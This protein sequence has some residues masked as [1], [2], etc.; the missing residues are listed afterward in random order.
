MDTFHNV[1][2]DEDNILD[3]IYISKYV[4]IFIMMIFDLNN[5]IRKCILTLNYH[6]NPILWALSCRE[7][8]FFKYEFS[9]ITL[10]TLNLHNKS[11]NTFALYIWSKMLS[12]S[13]D[14]LLKVSKTTYPQKL[15]AYDCV[16]L[17]NML[18]TLCH[19]AELWF[20]IFVTWKI[21]RIRIS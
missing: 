3:Q 21:V 13:L 11:P 15:F 7:L 16:T 17:Y 18:T 4:R 5:I 1:S 2:R 6:E 9:S 8:G 14:T 19:N 10:K 12:S 20:L